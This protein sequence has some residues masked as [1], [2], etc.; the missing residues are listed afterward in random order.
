LLIGLLVGTAEVLLFF[1]I[2]FGEG[3][4]VIGKLVIALSLPTEIPILSGCSG[5]LTRLV[6]ASVILVGII[7]ITFA[8]GVVTLG[9]V[10]WSAVIVSIAF[11]VGGAL[12]TLVVVGSA[13]VVPFAT[14]VALV[15]F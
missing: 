13:T 3:L 10:G 2:R 7:S 8:L 9:L 4:G 12:V 15:S 6:V 11:V 1:F 14:F 5:S